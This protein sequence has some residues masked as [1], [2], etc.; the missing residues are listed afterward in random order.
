MAVG[1]ADDRGSPCV[2]E[3]SHTPGPL[4]SASSLI[5][6]YGN[7]SMYI[8]FFLNEGFWDFWDFWS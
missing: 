3:P 1:K 4:L 7:K 2:G 6:I 8:F 5:L